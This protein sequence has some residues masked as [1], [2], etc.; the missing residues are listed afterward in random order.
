MR[1][2]PLLLASGMLSFAGQPPAPGQ[3]PA[4]AAPTGRGAQGS[5]APQ[6]ASPEITAEKRI[7]FRLFAPDATTVTLRGGDI[8]APARANAQFV[9]GASGVWEMTTGVVEPGAY[10]YVFVVNG[11]GVIDP[12]T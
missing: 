12:R 8:P 10:R 5:Q 11:V 6:F 9:K 4:P 2:L 1:L 3:V 7:V